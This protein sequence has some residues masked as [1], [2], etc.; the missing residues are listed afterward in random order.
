MTTKYTK[1]K[2][3]EILIEGNEKMT[4]YMGQVAEAI[5]SFNDSNLLHLKAI[6]INT[7]ATQQMATSVKSQTALVKWILIVLVLALVALAGAEKILK[8]I[9]SL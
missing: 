5:R 2:L 6:D 4:N 1:D 9:P 7:R 8:F 3:T